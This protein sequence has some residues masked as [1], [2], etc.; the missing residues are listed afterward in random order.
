MSRVFK[1]IARFLSHF[2][3]YLTVSV[4]P[5]KG[6]V[7]FDYNNGKW[8]K[9]H[10]WTNQQERKQLDEL[11]ENR[12]TYMRDDILVAIVMC[13]GRYGEC[14][15]VQVLYPKPGKYPRVPKLW[16]RF[17]CDLYKFP[18]AMTDATF[19]CQELA[20]ALGYREPETE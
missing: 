4:S 14:G 17:F 12:V 19:K 8:E 2:A 13:Y 11:V 16:E 6:G 3:A 20:K 7:L 9:L 5:E 1:K 10:Q 15:I 18:E